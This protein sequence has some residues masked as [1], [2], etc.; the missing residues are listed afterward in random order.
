MVEE[1]LD[2]LVVPIGDSGPRLYLFQIGSASSKVETQASLLSSL[3]TVRRVRAEL[4]E[5]CTMVSLV[6]HDYMQQPGVF[7]D[8]LTTLHEGQVP[9]LQT[10]DSDY[11]LSVLIPEAEMNRAVRLL[12]DRFNLAAAS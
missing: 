6:G 1:I 7:L 4:T 3:G 5:G 2:G 10:S 11:S 8:V 9:V 12:H